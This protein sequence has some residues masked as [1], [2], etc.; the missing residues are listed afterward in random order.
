MKTRLVLYFYLNLDTQYINPIGLNYRLLVSLI[1]NILL[2]S[3]NKLLLFLL[4]FTIISCQTSESVPIQKEIDPAEMLANQQLTTRFDSLFHS[5][6]AKTPRGGAAVVIV[7]DDRVI[8]QKG[9]GKKNEHQDTKVDTN[10]VFRLGSVS[11]NFASILAG[12]LVE[13]GVF[14]WE[15]RVKKYVPSFTLD[16]LAQAKRIEIQHLLSHSTGLPRHTYT[17]L[18]EAGIPIEQVIPQL[19]DA[20]VIAE[21]G[22]LFAYQNAAYAVIESVIENTTE[23]AFTD[24][25]QTKLLSPLGMDNTSYTFESIDNQENKAVPHNYNATP[26]AISK[27]YY[28]AVSAGGINASIADMGK[29]LLLLLGNEPDLIKA[30]TLADIYQPR[31]DCNCKRYYRNWEAVDTSY[32]GMGWRVLDYHEH[33]MVYHGGLVNNYRSEIALDL[34]TRTGICVLFNSKNELASKVIPMFFDLQHE[35]E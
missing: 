29:W 21:E 28:N 20:K 4:L 24:L 16:N 23:R 17:N 35:L 13:E 7:K 9:F 3:M 22:K 25:L 18:I 33:P 19:D 34:E 31:V 5:E 6:F 10:T 30:E 2:L 26:V 12:T 27:K 32:Y 1:T 15:D 8:Y 11:K 14:N